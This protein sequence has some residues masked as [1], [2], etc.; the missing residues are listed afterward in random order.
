MDFI[1]SISRERFTTSNVR[2]RIPHSDI[3]GCFAFVAIKIP[4]GF[5]GID[6]VVHLGVIGI[7][8]VSYPLPFVH[9][10]K[11]VLFNAS[12]PILEL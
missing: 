4:H 12:I 1:Q 9:C 8:M 6:G 11:R 7:I 2:I 10:I 3:I 5:I